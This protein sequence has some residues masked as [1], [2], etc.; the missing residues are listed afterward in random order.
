MAGQLTGKG[1]SDILKMFGVGKQPGEKLT[2]REIFEN[3]GTI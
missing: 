2:T 1:I 3:V